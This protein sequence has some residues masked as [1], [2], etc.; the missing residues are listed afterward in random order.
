MNSSVPYQPHFKMPFTSPIDDSMAGTSDSTEESDL[1]EPT[2]V[3]SSS[4]AKEQ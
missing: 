3:R 4:L 1:R 2:S